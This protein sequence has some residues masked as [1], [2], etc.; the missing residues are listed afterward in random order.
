[1]SPR[2]GIRNGL[3]CGVAL[4]MLLADTLQPALA[5]PA[6]RKPQK[7][8][9]KQKPRTW[10]YGVTTAVLKTTQ[11]D[12]TLRFFFDKAP[13]NVRNFVDLAAGG[14]YDNTLFHRV[15]P[16][17]VVQGGDP[18]TKDPKVSPELYGTGSHLDS[19]GRPVTVKSEPNDIPHRRGVVSMAAKASDPDS[20][21]SQFFFVLRDYPSLNGKFTVFAEVLS[22]MDVLDRIVQTSN[23]DLNDR[24]GGRPRMPQRLIKIE[25][26]EE[27]SPKS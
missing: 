23:S 19:S 10:N 9:A 24:N 18:L 4:A 12:V 26:I 17:F 7:K 8:D 27:G 25:L 3:L 14:L 11:G 2:Q 1:M 21:S 15:I 22:G 16:E 13:N 20:A 5:M 6:T